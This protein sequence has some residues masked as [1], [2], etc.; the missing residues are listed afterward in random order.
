MAAK[1][2]STQPGIDGRLNLN[3]SPAERNK[4]DVK[5]LA[6][7]TRTR[8]TVQQP[9]RFLSAPAIY[10]SFLAPRDRYSFP[11]PLTDGYLEI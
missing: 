2:S 1:T 3:A 5:T 7:I 11:D 8:N 6:T 4:M 10:F 9:P